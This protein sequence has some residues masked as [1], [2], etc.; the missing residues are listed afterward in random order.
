M[1]TLEY[2]RLFNIFIA[3]LALVV[4][5]VKAFRFKFFTHM[6]VDSMMGF[7]AVM[8]W[9]LAYAIAA[10]LATLEEVQTG[11]WTII[12]GI[13]CIWTLVAGLMGWNRDLNEKDIDHLKLGALSPNEVR[14]RRGLPKHEGSE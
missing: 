9:C 6:T 14:R 11:L 5:T 12:M 3:G 8:A 4:N 2:F 1:E 7:N 10:S 13:P